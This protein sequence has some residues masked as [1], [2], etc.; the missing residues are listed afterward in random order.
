MRELTIAFRA[1]EKEKEILEKLAKQE[2]RSIANFVR[3]LI[4][5]ALDDHYKT[6]FEED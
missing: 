1:T 4:I 5:L 3:H 6:E 2:H